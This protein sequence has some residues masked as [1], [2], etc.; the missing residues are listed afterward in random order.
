MLAD[1]IP[2]NDT[3]FKSIGGVFIANYIPFTQEQIEQ[4]AATDLAAFLHSRGE[5]LITSGREKRLASDRSVTIRGSEWYDHAEQRGGN[6]ISFLQQYNGMSFPEAMQALFGG[7]FR[8]AEPI[9]PEP[10]PF[11][12]PEANAD[13]RRVFAYLTKTRGID[14]RVVS[15][16][17]HSGLIYEDSRYHNAVFVGKDESRKA[18]HAHVR[19]TNSRGKTF[20][21]NIEGSDPRYSFHHIGTNG[22]LLVF[23][24]PIDLL[25]HISLYPRNWQENSYVACCGTSI[26]PVLKTL[27]QM[28]Q[29]DTVLLCMDN[30]EAGQKS[31]RRVAAQLEAEGLTVI[32]QTPKMKDWNDDLLAS[33]QHT[34]Q[35]A[36]L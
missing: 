2:A 16:F 36:G 9:R 6:A 32:P 8:P 20:R 1:S 14:K 25:S 7:D 26:Q 35:P 17:A 33:Q 34:L 4:A 29:A 5:K 3:S 23:E 28:P 27:E 31:N 21:I 12:L 24:A 11:A 15:A 13:M 22:S 19:S 10:K 18:V 30:D